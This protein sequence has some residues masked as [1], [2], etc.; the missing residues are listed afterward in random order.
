MPF[1][2]LVKPETLLDAFHLLKSAITNSNLEP[3]QFYETNL[4]NSQKIT[5]A[6][7][8]QYATMVCSDAKNKVI[9]SWRNDQNPEIICAPLGGERTEQYYNDNQKTI[10]ADC[11]GMLSNIFENT[12]QSESIAFVKTNNRRFLAQ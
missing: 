10:E 4:G 3:D 12:R 9:Y 2:N 11:L 6:H 7:S 5:Y 8:G 1:E